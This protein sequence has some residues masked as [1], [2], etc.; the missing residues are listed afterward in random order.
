MYSCTSTVFLCGQLS[1]T[2]CTSLNNVFALL[3]VGIRVP[4]A[5]VFCL[6]VPPFPV[7]F[8]PPPATVA[9]NP[10]CSFSSRLSSSTL[11]QCSAMASEGSNLYCSK[12]QILHIFTS[13]RRRRRGFTLKQQLRTKTHHQCQLVCSGCT[14]CTG[15]WRDISSPLQQEK[16]CTVRALDNVPTCSH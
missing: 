3:E 5:C 15:V 9:A 16:T 12:H 11:S 14:T 1:I 4:S 8:S 6:N 13:L 10:G 2:N 7:P